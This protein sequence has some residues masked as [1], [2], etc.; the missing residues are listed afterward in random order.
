MKKY[1]TF[2]LMLA[3]VASASAESQQFSSR[4]TR[5]RTQQQR[6]T[7]VAPGTRAVGAFPRV[8][9]NPGQLLNPKAPPQYYGPPQETV[10]PDPYNM[11]GYRRA[12]DGAAYTGLILFGI[13]W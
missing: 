1:L 11:T 5:Q 3:A 2:A 10:A 7:N 8:S 13:S 9:R 12:R 4:V 6:Q